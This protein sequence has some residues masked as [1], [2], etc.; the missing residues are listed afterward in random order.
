MPP[1]DSARRASLENADTLATVFPSLAGAM[2][3]PAERRRILKLMAASLALAGCDPGSP[4][5]KWV[6]TAVAP[7]GIVPSLPDRYTTAIPSGGAA[8]G[9]VVTHDSGRPIKVEG[10]PLHPASLGATDALAQAEILNL[11]DP[12]RSIGLLKSGD[13]TSS[14]RLEAALLPLRERLA[15]TNGAGLRILTETC[16]SPSLGA[17]LDGVLARYPEARWHQTT[18]APRDSLRAGAILA[19]GQPL[20]MVPRPAVVDVILGL[21][22]DLASGAPFWVRAA[23]DLASRR[24]P[25]LGPP[26]RIFAL[27]AIPTGLG[28]LAD[29]RIPAGPTDMHAAVT[30][31][32]AAILTSAAPTGPA[33]LPPIVAALKAAAGRALIHAGPDLPPETHALVFAMNEALGGRGQTYDL[34]DPP[35]HRSEDHTSSFASL[36]AD[37]DAGR[38]EALF[39][40]DTNPVFTAPGFAEA[41]KRVPFSLHAGPAPNETALAAAWHVPLAHPFEQWSDLSAHDG[42][43]RCECSPI[44]WPRMCRSAIASRLA[45]VQFWSRM[46]RRLV[47]T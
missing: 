40:L 36:R 15:A 38:V 20:V 39:I 43:C 42:T 21:D 47:A 9:L 10:N 17:A 13:P 16:L 12:D 29:T 37:V 45:W 18:V 3:Q 5:S 32:A 25:V 26:S 24:N 14:A 1:L 44:S 34:L 28:A 19:Y 6:P 23:R 35:E 46:P 33:W 4:G 2:A 30:A 11:Y 22:S 27:E 8:I 7:P 41:L 31:L